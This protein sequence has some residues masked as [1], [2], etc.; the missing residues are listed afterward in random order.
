MI[1]LS[2]LQE[3]IIV[4]NSMHQI[5]ELQNTK[6]KLTKLNGEADNFTATVE[7]FNVIGL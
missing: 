2:V 5:R 1:K 7:E 6:Q 3:D 4:I